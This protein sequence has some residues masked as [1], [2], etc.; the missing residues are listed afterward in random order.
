[1]IALE[2]KTKLF[3]YQQNAVNKLLPIRVGAL[4]MDMGTGKTRTAIELVKKRMSKISKLIWICPVSLKETIRKEILKHTDTNSIYVFNQKTQDDDIPQA[5]WY[6][7]GTE[8]IG[9]SDRVTLALNQLID[10]DTFMIVDESSYI[11][12]HK[13]KRTQRLTLL[14]KRCKYRLILT[15]TP[16]TQGIVDLYSQMKFLSEKIL[17]YKSFY[18]FANNHL[19]YSERFSNLIVKTFHEEYL[20]VKIAPYVYQIKKEDCLDLP[21]KIYDNRY[22]T[23]SDEQRA[24]Y[25]KT[26]EDFLHNINPY[27]FSS[28]DIF[29]LFMTLQQIISGYKNIDVKETIYY[30]ENDR[31][32]V[33]KDIIKS[34]HTDKKIIIWAKYHYDLELIEKELGNEASLFSGKMNEK[35]KEESIQSFRNNKRFFIATPSSGGYG[36]TLNESHYVIFYNNSFKYGERLQAEDR[37]HRIGQTEKVTYIDIIA[38]ESIDEKIKQA[39]NLKQSV[40][41]T[42][43]EEIDKIKDKKTLKEFIKNI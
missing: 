39:L 30:K 1:M 38:S 42:F 9:Q 16:M 23:M 32:E 36:L 8:S 3:T 7:V 10:E 40:A 14:G 26:K 11:K 41:E 19:E 4:F 27:D 24:A 13:S 21:K 15:G 29:K 43:K 25:N 37:C 33:L 22:F 20:A 18:S 28:F 17:E 12:G 5:D 6:I 35:Q 2:T 31:I 34:I